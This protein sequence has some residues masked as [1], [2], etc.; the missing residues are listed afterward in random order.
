[1]VGTLRSGCT[2]CCGV[3]SVDVNLVYRLLV[4]RIP[5][6]IAANLNLVSPSNQVESARWSVGPHQWLA[7]IA[8]LS[9]FAT[10]VR[11]TVL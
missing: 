3:M 2:H 6:N 9:E 1:V 8:S 11:I 10:I 7:R 5:R 4:R